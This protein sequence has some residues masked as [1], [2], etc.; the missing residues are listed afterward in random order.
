MRSVNK[1]NKLIVILATVV[2]TLLF[3]FIGLA[4]NYYTSN[5][6][7]KE[8]PQKEIKVEQKEEVKKEKKRK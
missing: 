5:K 3:I 2:T 1:Q 4:V 7:A 8:V 6:V